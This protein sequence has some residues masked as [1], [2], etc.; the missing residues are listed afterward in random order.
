MR[1]FVF[2]GTVALITV[3]CAE[4]P[5]EPVESSAAESSEV[6][7]TP[8]AITGPL[9]AEVNKE[10]LE[11]VLAENSVTLVDFTATWCGPCQLLKPE[12]HKMA[13]DFAGK[14]RFVEVDVDKSEDLAREYKIA[15]MPTLLI[16][17]NGEVHDRIVGGGDV[18]AIRAAIQ[19]A[20]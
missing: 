14:A 10:N 18:G 7:H 20:L 16:M 17:K 4:P 12:L 3:G 2:A 13:K 9:V 5:S 8:A 1:L 11:K 6:E 19:S 15:A